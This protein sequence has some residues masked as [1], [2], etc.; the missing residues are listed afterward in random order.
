MSVVLLTGFGAYEEEGRNPS[1]AIAAELDGC[2]YGAVLIRGI[3]LPVSSKRV[4]AIL[5]ETIETVRPDILLITGVTPGRQ[6]VAIE[7]VAINIRDFPIPDVDG[8][9]PVDQPIVKTGPAAYFSSLPIKAILA[10]WREKEVPAYVSNSAGTYLCNEAFYMACHLTAAKG[11]PTGLVHIPSSS[12]NAAGIV[13]P[14][15]SLCLDLLLDAVRT[16]ALV[17]ARHEGPDMKLGAGSTS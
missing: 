16:A 2:Q 7:R 9:V 1:G 10:A 6:A 11:I 17:A 3:V 14:P 15:P 4:A 13:P 8:A 12:S 5:A